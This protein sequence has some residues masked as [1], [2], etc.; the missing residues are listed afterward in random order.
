MPNSSS[1]FG[2]VPPEV[3]PGGLNR[4]LL[5]DRDGPAVGRLRLLLP[6]G[7]SQQY[8][9]V[10]VS[11][12]QVVADVVPGWEPAGQLLLDRLGVAVCHLCIVEFTEG[13][14][15]ATDAEKALGLAVTALGIAGLGGGEHR[16]VLQYLLQELAVFVCQLRL[17]P[18]QLFHHLI[19][20][21]VQ[22]PLRLAAG[23]F[24]FIARRQG[25]L[26]RGECPDQTDR[27]AD[28]RRQHTK[29]TITLAASTGPLFRRTNFRSR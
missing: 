14:A 24:L 15:D 5:P 10:M 3:G 21:R 9:E 2:Q 29:S 1:A 4:E 20:H 12:S 26:L 28:D 16:V 19:R 25:L 17:R 27:R 8:G 23:L 7:G 6:A 22:G 11:Q 13:I 18:Q